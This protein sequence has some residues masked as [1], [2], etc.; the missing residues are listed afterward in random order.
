MIE[1]NELQEVQQSRPKNH[2]MELIN[3]ND[4]QTVKNQLN[5]INQFQ[6]VVNQTLKKGKDY[7]EIPGTGSKPTLLKAGAE[8]IFM[9]MGLSS[10]FDIIDKQEDWENGFFQYTFKT[11]LIKDGMI[12]TEGLGSANTKEKKYIKNDGFSIQNTIL[13][14]AKKRSEVDAALT[15]G[16][17]SD[18]FTQ[19]IEDMVD[20]YRAH[21]NVDTMTQ[22]EAHKFVMK[23]GKYR[24][25]TLS[26][27]AEENAG[28]LS[29]IVKNIDDK[30]DLV[31]AA[32][33][34][35]DER[36]GKTSAE[37]SKPKPKATVKKATAKQKDKIKNLVDTLSSMQKLEPIEVL[38]N[39]KAVHYQELTEEQAARFIQALEKDSAEGLEPPEPDDNDPFAKNGNEVDIS[40]DDLPF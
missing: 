32:Q 34:L 2:L 38:K 22:D 15:V 36:E 25:K 12:I 17:L 16:S 20:N 37:T 35:I 7:G 10:K 33:M 29:W 18:L 6:E 40:K 13:K 23:N 21:E 3:S 26:E 4:V 9:L 19:D 8:K 11:T 27:I 30:P 5:A 1:Q 14:M 24:G 39:Y 31:K 28:Y